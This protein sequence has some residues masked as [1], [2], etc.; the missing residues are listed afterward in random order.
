MSGRH[1]RVALRDSRH[2]VCDGADEQRQ[3]D[4]VVVAERSKAAVAGACA[5]Q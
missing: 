2:V 5:D 1:H 3:A 4:P